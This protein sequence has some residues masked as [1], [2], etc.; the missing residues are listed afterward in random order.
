M[1]D[2][3]PVDD[4]LILPPTLPGKGL[5]EEWRLSVFAGPVVREPWHHADVRHYPGYQIDDDP[6]VATWDCVTPIQ[7][8]LPWADGTFAGVVANHGLQALTYGDL[9]P[10]LVE[11][12][13]VLARGGTL[14]ILVPDLL[15]GI[16]A[17]NERRPEHFVVADEH[18]R[19][20]AGKLC[21]YVTQGGATRT[22]FTEEWLVELLGRAGFTEIA[23]TGPGETVYGPSWITE[24]DSR[25][26]ESLHVECRR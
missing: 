2:L 18:E 8:G 17:F 23:P 9:V 1:S 26:E 22:V 11:L 6:T 12:R 15:A 16:R 13:R 3:L 14:R 21:L 19:T 7:R 10:A 25:P 4:G 5:D 24:L 20:L